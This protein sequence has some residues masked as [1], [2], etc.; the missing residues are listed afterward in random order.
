MDEICADD[1][2]TLHAIEEVMI[3]NMPGFIVSRDD[4]FDFLVGT[5]T[6]ML[7]DE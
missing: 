7:G 5:M 4:V 1:A 3:R 6:E 2:R